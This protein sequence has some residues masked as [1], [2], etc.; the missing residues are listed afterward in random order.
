MSTDVIMPALGMAQDT[1]KVL[2]WRKA[3]GEAVVRGEPLVEV[4][5]DKVTVEIEAPASGVLAN[6]TVAPGDEVPVGQVIAVIQGPGA[7][8]PLSPEGRADAESVPAQRVRPARTQREAPPRHSG[9]PASPV[10]PAV[11]MTRVS[12]VAARIAAQHDVD[13]RL[14]ESL[15]SAFG[16]VEPAGGRIRKDDVLLHVAAQQT[17]APA[18]HRARRIPSSPNARRLAAERGID[19]ARLSGTGPDG[20]VLTADV[21]AAAATTEP[22]HPAVTGT[23]A[24]AHE[25]AAAALPATGAG[26]RPAPVSTT[27][28]LMAERVMQSWTSV[29]HFYLFRTVDAGRLVAWHESVRRHGRHQDVKITYTDLLVR[30]VAAALRAH[31]RLNAA[32]VDGAISLNDAVN[33]GLAVAVEDG[34]VVPVVQRADELGLREIAAR[35][36]DLV[37]RAQAGRLRPEDVR[38]G[39]FTISNLG[40]YGVDSAS[41]IINPPQ[42]AIL[43]VGRIAERVVPVDG[44]PAVRS[45]MDLTLSC[46][47]RVVDGARGAQFLAT[48]AELIEEPLALVE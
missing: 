25:E 45:M 38:G 35:R 33:V 22:S 2:H 32:F 40:M 27:W 48:L 3:P 12:P 14:V 31:P 10:A 26:H 30:L 9:D 15:T 43:A 28:R 4:E 20:A 24:A 34:L 18:R 23:V 7:A 39:T 46:D 17:G 16:G 44:Q 5:T 11:A 13:L 47:H 19:I 8:V 21:L 42:A 29:P 6:V 37:A 36:Q 1:G 41:A